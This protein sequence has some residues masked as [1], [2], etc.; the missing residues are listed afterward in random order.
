MMR[1]SPRLALCAVISAAWLASP[2]RADRYEA[3]IAIRPAGQIA[4]IADRGTGELAVV[5][6]GGFAGG[7]SW[8]LRNWLDLGGELAVS[9]FG[10]ASYELATLPIGANPR[11]GNLS[12]RTGTM[13]LRG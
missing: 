7:L 10:E 13:Q 5:P 4:R 1:R 3:S 11:T 6:G 9:S 2:A 8:G 12:R